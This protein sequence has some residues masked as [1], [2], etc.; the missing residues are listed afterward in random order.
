MGSCTLISFT[1]TG[2]AY[3]FQRWQKDVLFIF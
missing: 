1:V 2:D 3:R